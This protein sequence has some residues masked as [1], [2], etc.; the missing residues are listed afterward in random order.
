MSCPQVAKCYFSLVM[1]EESTHTVHVGR[2]VVSSDILMR[3]GVKCINYKIKNASWIIV[4]YEETMLC[5]LLSTID[6]KFDDFT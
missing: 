1:S 3:P 2:Q 4:I 6:N 5:K